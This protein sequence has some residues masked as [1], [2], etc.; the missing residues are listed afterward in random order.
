MLQELTVKQFHQ[1]IARA[2]LASDRGISRYGAD[3]YDGRMQA[4]RLCQIT[5]SST[6]E[7]LLDTTRTESEGEEKSEENPQETEPLPETST[8]VP[9]TRLEFSTVTA[10]ESTSNPILMFAALPPP[11]LRSAQKD[12]IS[13]VSTIPKLVSVDR[14]MKEI[15]IQ[16]RRARK[17]KLKAEET[18][19]SKEKS[20]NGDDGTSMEQLL[21]GVRKTVIA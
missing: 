21:E 16:I 15:E 4:S 8:S 13:M 6:S 5:V 3:R 20:T 11:T 19:S 18:E 9:T 7:P 2:N 12:T 17:Y 10:T 1:S 14:E